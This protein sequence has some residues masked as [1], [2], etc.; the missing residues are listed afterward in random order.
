MA[1]L[2]QKNGVYVARFRFRRKEYQKSLRTRGRKAA[3]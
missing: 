1:N 3:D 2:S